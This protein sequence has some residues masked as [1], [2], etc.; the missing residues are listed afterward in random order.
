M[1]EFKQFEGKLSESASH[2][3]AVM[4]LKE[5]LETIGDNLYVYAYLKADEDNRISE[6]QEL[7][8]RIGAVYAQY[9]AATSFIEPELLAMSGETKQNFLK[10]TPELDEFRFYLN[11]LERQK[12]HIL[13]QKEEEL[14]AA[15]GPMAQTA[16][17]VFN[18]ID[19]ADLKLGTIIDDEGKPL[20]LTW[21]RYSRI[22]EESSREVRQAAN[23]TVQVQYLKYVNALAATLSGSVKK[24]L[25][26]AKAR[27]YEDCLSYSLDGNNIST[28]VYYNLIDAVNANL[29]PL[30]KLTALRKKILKVDTLYTYDMSVPL[31]PKSD[32]KYSYEEAKEMLL[33]GLAPMGDTYIKDFDKGLSSGWVDVYETEGKGTGAYS[34]GTY[35]SHPYIMMNYTDRLDDVFTLAHEMGHAMNSYYTNSHEPFQYAGH[36]LFTAEVAS[37]CNEAVLMKFMLERVKNK[38]EKIALLNHYINQIKGTFFTQVMFAEF[39]LAIHNHVENGGAISVDYLR[40]TYRDIYQ[41]Y[42]G[43]DLVIPENNDLTGMK[44]SHFYRQYYV[45]QYATCYA[46]AQMLSQRII[47]GEEGILDTYQQFLNTG[48]SKYPVDILKD[49]GVDMTQP[50]AVN[51]TLQLFSDLVDEMEKLLSEG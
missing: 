28:D 35:S 8:Q 49:A 26:F 41:K 45:Y 13:S 38:E 15:A 11:D 16:S 7:G 9:S 33:K 19:N 25:F 29:E 17:T 36:A 10:S 20:D 4:K 23:D 31:G 24:D 44:I 47:D 34:W 40:K 2:I 46:A 5:E 48:T 42:Y 39:E 27:G 12:E 21:G 30:H 43:P 32:K 22:M 18:M 1:G 3:V 50:E 37:T 14:L 51:R 6:Y